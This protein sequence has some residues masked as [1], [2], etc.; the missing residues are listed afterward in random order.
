MDIAFEYY[1]YI[2]CSL[3]KLLSRHQHKRHTMP[4]C[5]IYEDR[6]RSKS[7]CVASAVRGDC[8]IL[9]FVKMAVLIV[10]FILTSNCT[11]SIHWLDFF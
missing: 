8:F 5:I 9:P 7:R 4:A 11:P 2:S 6:H 1:P 3:I 10:L